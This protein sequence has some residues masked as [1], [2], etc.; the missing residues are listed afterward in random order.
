MSLTQ[1][2][3]E[4]SVEDGI[5][6]LIKAF[7]QGQFKDSVFDPEKYVNYKLNYSLD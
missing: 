6:E 5:D 7:N 1:N 3:T 4:K 2:L